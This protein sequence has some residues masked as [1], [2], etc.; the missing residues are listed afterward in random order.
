[1]PQQPAEEAAAAN[2][3]RLERVGSPQ[4]RIRSDWTCD[5][6]RQAGRIK[7]AGWRTSCCLRNGAIPQALVRPMGIVEVDVLTF[8]VVEMAKAK[9][10]EVIQAF[11]LERAD[12]RFHERVCLRRGMHPARPMWD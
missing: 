3:A 5:L 1:M 4:E 11:P 9:A 7:C 12:P 8:D 6:F 2:V 10:Q